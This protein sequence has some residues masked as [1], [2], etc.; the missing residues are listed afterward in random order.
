MGAPISSAVL[1]FNLREGRTCKPAGPISCVT[2]LSGRPFAPC[3]NV[4]L[5]L[6]V[7]PWM[8]ETPHQKFKQVLD[9]AG[10]PRDKG[11]PLYRSTC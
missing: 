11:V 6:L 1:R 9:V 3:N 8:A 5:F 7:L 2:I 10:T 4:V